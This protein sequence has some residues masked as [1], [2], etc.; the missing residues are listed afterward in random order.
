MSKFIKTILLLS[1]GFVAGWQ[2]KPHSV[3]LEENSSVVVHAAPGAQIN[4]D[5][6]NNLN[7]SWVDLFSDPKMLNNDQIGAVAELLKSEMAQDEKNEVNLRLI[8]YAKQLLEKNNNFYDAE[9]KLI[10]LLANSETKETVLDYLARLYEKNERYVEAINT[11]Y[12]LKDHTRY[13]DDLIAI[14]GRILYLVNSNVER[15]M[16][17]HSLDKL[18]AF[19]SLIIYKEPDN[20]AYQMKYAEFS[21]KNKNYEQASVLLD[22]LVHHQDYMVEAKRLLSRVNHHKS[23]IQSGEFPVPVS[24]M[25]EHYIVTAII[26]DQEP[27][28]LIIDTGASMTVL[29]PEIMRGLNIEDEDVIT[30]TNFSTANG[31]VNA[32]VILVDK[33]KVQNYVV[34]N[35]KVGIL[36]SFSQSNVDGLLGMNFLNQ[37]T[38]FID[39][40]NSTLE[41][42]SIN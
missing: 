15:L 5:D 13:T 29:S 22:V 35:V 26:N 40:E 17:S 9:K 10:A 28:K 7:F 25:G 4:R 42:S 19:Y 8:A 41:L 27:V 32:P 30:Y 36:S 2:L 1:F 33:I 31:V 12:D 6:G 14:D 39:Q 3:L 11:L 34:S 23:V 20:Y 24:K 16:E 38:F 37:F 21:Y 18:D